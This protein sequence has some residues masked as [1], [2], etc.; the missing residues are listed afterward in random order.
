MVLGKSAALDDLKYREVKSKF[1]RSIP[2]PIVNQE[3]KASP[4]ILRLRDS[5][6]ELKFPLK[7]L[8]YVCDYPWDTDSFQ[9]CSV[10]IGVCG[11]YLAEAISICS[12]VGGVIDD[13]RE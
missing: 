9:K 10:N 1:G 12:A 5:I 4:P 6:G 11:S 8:K 7:N 2:S 3:S 13:V